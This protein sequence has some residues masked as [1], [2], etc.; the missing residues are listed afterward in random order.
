MNEVLGIGFGTLMGVFIG[1]AT[2]YLAIRMLFRPHRPWRIGQWTLPFTPGLI[3][4]R[5]GALA[6]QLG[7]LV[8]R[9]L[10]T[11]KGLR[12][13]MASPAWRNAV[14]AWVRRCLRRALT[15]ER[16]LCDI[17]AALPG[18]VRRTGLRLFLRLVREGETVATAVLRRRLVGAGAQPI[19]ALVPPNVRV[20]VE[21]LA[22]RAAPHVARLLADFLASEKGRRALARIVREAVAQR[23]V[24]G[25]LAGA[26]LPEERVALGL[27]RVLADRLRRPA[28]E[29][30]LARLL[31][32][33]VTELW[34]C[35]AVTFVTML[36]ERPGSHLVTRLLR[37]LASPRWAEVTLAEM[38]RLLPARVVDVWIPAAVLA[39]LDGLAAR[40]DRLL[41][42]LPLAEAVREEV[43]AFSLPELEARIVEVAGRELRWIT[44]IGAVIGGVVGAVQTVI[45][46]GLG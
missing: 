27:S 7:E 46:W 38:G 21:R 18:E 29:D 19:G 8:A 35:P 1:G 17:V 37:L 12:R 44:W 41:G 34:R 36:P 11:A 33:L 40:A 26:L 30:A 15:D 4:K 31:R 13:A 3:P 25:A 2:N 42:S 23:G 24:V 28:A 5:H 32:A 45:L 43:E 9:H 6:R 16:P 14:T 39:I 20:G 10:V 22:E